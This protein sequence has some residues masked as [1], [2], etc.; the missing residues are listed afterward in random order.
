MSRTSEREPWGPREWLI[1]G[2]LGA[3]LGILIGAAIGAESDAIGLAILGSVP[4]SLMVF[5]GLI[6]KAVQ[7]GIRSAQ[8]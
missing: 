7:V 3:F 4:G 1:G 8:D 6:A 5:I 2:L